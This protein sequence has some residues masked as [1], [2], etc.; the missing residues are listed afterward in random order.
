[1]QMTVGFASKRK[2]QALLLGLLIVGLIWEMSKWIIAGSDQT[3][4][5]FGLS[6]VACATLIQILY[7]WRSGVLIFLIWLLFEDLAR[8]YLGNSL[9]VFFAKDFLVGAAYLSYYLAKRRREVESFKIPFQLPFLMFFFLACIQIFN[10]NSPNVLYG[11]AG[12][13]VY[14]YYVPL[15]YLGYGM[16]RSPK[17]LDNFF[18]VSLVAGII[19]ALLG[20][21]QSVLGLS[22]LTPDDI[23][24]ELYELTHV[25]RVSPITHELSTMTSSVFVS[26]GRFSFYLILL[27]IM[28]MG[29]QGYMLL[30]R[31][32]GAIYGFL[33]IGVVSAAILVT[34]ART[35][36]VFTVLSALVMSA[37]FLWGAPWRWG[38]GHRLVTA[39]RRA[40]LVGAVGVILLAEVFP[41]VLGGHWAFLSETLAY[42]GEGSELQSRG[43]QYPVDNL[44]KAFQY[45]HWFMGYGTG[46]DSLT[47]NYVARFLNEP[48]PSIGVESGWGS[49]ILEMGLLGPFMWLVWTTSALW[50]GWKV[51][52][53]LRQTVYFPI[54]FA[55]WWYSFILLFLFM[56]FGLPPYQ[57]YVNNAYM[58]LL[59]G[60][61]FALPKLAEMPVPIAIPKHLRA[62]PRWRLAL[63]GK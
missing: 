17:D 31:R 30:S 38:Q 6:L 19:I 50:A 54:A 42:Q 15:I 46:L 33:G 51:V 8:K 22:F 49:I 48:P 53:R 7:D 4:I 61:L 27:W 56:Y 21:A 16:M 9:L 45:E 11:L 43:W 28:A 18:T 35:P 20:I 26:S 2:V 59:L 25:T 63:I 44:G 10:V 36:F 55:I 24:P 23:A 62:V 3:L 12:L 40:L 58:W 34:G 41:N 13:Q 39:L 57:N 29:A 32:R 47:K 52:K 37:A 14:F 5:M 1:M 60:V